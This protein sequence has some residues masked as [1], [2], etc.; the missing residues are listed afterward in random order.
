VALDYYNSF[1]MPEHGMDWPFSLQFSLHNTCN[2]ACVMC[3]ADRSSRIRTQRS[4]LAPLP[5]VY[6]DRFFEEIEAF[7]HHA[8]AVDFSGGEPFL[9]QEH[10]RLWEMLIAMDER[11][12][13]SLTTNG[14]V[15]N[16]RTERVL[17][18]LDTHISVSIDGITRQTFE[19]VRVGG[20]FDDAMRNLERF[21][22]YT[23]E[24]GTRL[25]LSWSLVRGNWFE[26]GSA[27][28]FAEERDIP[29]K[30]L[31]V[32]E[33]DYGLQR[34]PTNELAWVVR[35]MEAES[36]DLLSDLVINRETW[37]REVERLSGELEARGG[38]RVRPLCMEP[39]APGNVDHIVQLML[40]TAGRP[41][42][43]PDSQAAIAR[44]TADIQR[45]CG[46]VEPV[47]L[48]L[49]STGVLRLDAELELPGA[50]LGRLSIPAGTGMADLLREVESAL[51][52]LVWIG[53][54]W[55][56]PD[57]LVQT[58]WIG[59]SVRDKVG[60]VL[61][62]VSIGGPRGISVLFAADPVLLPEADQGVRVRLAPAQR[63]GARP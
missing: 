6:G 18:E 21:R 55:P 44:S 56:E 54:E 8:G 1:P 2:L 17:S 36:E 38:E 63:G 12:L 5:H 37:I 62:L 43:G 51:D 26:L 3:G 60:L 23:R 19:A 35:S 27:L 34:L 16:A 20:D 30:V 52:G 50:E 59:K 28:R 48:E 7:V 53:D 58:V 29:V 45:W 39:A 24:R 13:C 32:I 14:T 11:P 47:C 4:G 10:G 9:V 31:T 15:W 41:L 57:R 49:D 40:E 25:T 46:V 22:E 33:P 42:S 61:K